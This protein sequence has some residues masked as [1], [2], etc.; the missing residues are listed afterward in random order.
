MI[1]ILDVRQTPREMRPVYGAWPVARWWGYVVRGWFAALFVITMAVAWWFSEPEGFFRI[2]VCLLVSVYGLLGLGLIANRRIG[3]ATL[4]APLGDAASR[5]R[6]DQNGLR[7]MY[8]LGE[9]SLDWRAVVRVVE[10]K[11]R[12]IF[13]V[14]PGRNH[15]LPLR[16]FGPGQLDAFRALIAEV[17]TSGRLGSGIDGVHPGSA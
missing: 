4:A 3:R 9:Q 1:E 5:W 13:A 8:A 7:I 14:T 15:V 17:Q 2:A 11:D 12:F 16:C 10:E 6:F